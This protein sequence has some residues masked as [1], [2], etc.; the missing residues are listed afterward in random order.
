LLHSKVAVESKPRQ[1]WEIIALIQ[2]VVALLPSSPAE[3]K[4]SW[5]KFISQHQT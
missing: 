5:L 2:S 4:K 3:R 1:L